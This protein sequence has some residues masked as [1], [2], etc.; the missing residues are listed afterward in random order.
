MIYE[1]FSYFFKV[2]KLYEIINYNFRIYVS[3][4]VGSG[5]YLEI[6][7]FSIIKVF[8]FVVRGECMYIK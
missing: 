3:N 6:Y 2:N 8:S 4:D 1:G 7:I 5:F